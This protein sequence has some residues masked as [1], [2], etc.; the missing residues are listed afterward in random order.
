MMFLLKPCLF[1]VQTV[2]ELPAWWWR[3]SPRF[4]TFGRTRNFWQ[5]FFEAS[6]PVWDVKANQVDLFIIIVY[7]F[8]YLFRQWSLDLYHTQPHFLIMAVIQ[9]PCCIE[10]ILNMLKSQY[11]VCFPRWWL[12]TLGLIFLMSCLSFQQ[13]MASNMYCSVA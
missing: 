11:I 13:L 8:I 5:F 10:D 2:Q 3:M 9:F 7:L 4:Y 6:K 1:P 12:V